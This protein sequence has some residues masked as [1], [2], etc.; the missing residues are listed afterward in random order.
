VRGTPTSA[1][2]TREL[3]G[4]QPPPASLRGSRAPASTNE[5]PITCARHIHQPP[6]EN[7]IPLLANVDFPLEVKF[8]LY[9]PG[10]FNRGPNRVNSSLQVAGGP[11]C[12]KPKTRTAP[13]ARVRFDGM[14]PASSQPDSGRARYW[15]MHLPDAEL[16]VSVQGATPAPCLISSRQVFKLNTREFPECT[17]IA[18]RD[19]SET[20]LLPVA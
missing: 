1:A 8:K 2:R 16:C 13:E 7:Y 20:T 12:V 18:T 17:K 4:A 9:L 5:S 19:L 3:T 14:H 10:D 6:E 11:I 15:A